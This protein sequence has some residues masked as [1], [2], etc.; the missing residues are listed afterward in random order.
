[1]PVARTK[2][3]TGP[4]KWPP[5]T[6][7]RGGQ[8]RAM[9]DRIAGVYDVLNTAMTAGLH[10]HWR[11]RAADLARVGPGSR[12]LDVATGTGDL[13]IELA[14][15]V[16]PG[17]RGGRQRLLRGD[18]RSRPRQG[19]RRRGRRLCAH[20]SSGPTRW[21]CPTPRT[22]SMPPR[23][24]SAPATSPISRAVWPRWCAWCAP[25]GGWSCSRSLRRRVRRCRCSSASG[26]T[27][28][29]PCSAGWPAPA[30]R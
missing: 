1:M 10:H 3:Q 17:R 24:A 2:A 16:S 9:F 21:S 13:A 15:R 27:E 12:V 11:A 7:S 28:S 23:S 26:S 8:V 20:A 22:P 14:R 19:R 18:A 29:C 4:Q 5:G 30:P 6:I 25:A